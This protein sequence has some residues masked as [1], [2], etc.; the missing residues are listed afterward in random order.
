M[1]AAD[2]KPS[3]LPPEVVTVSRFIMGVI[4]WLKV[5]FLWV[6]QATSALTFKVKLLERRE[7]RTI[8]YGY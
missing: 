7:G 8:T 4:V 5:C 3:P 6:F 1:V 2:V